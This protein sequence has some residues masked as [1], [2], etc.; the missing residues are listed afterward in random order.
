[1]QWLWIFAFGGLGALARVGLAT[2]LGARAF[3]WSTLAVNLLGCLAIGV[4][5]VLFETL[6]SEAWRPWRVPLIGGFLGGFTTFSAFGLETFTLIGEG[7][8]GAALAYVVASVG[9]GVAGVALGAVLAR[10][11][12]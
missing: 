9:I 7:R 3:P 12:G 2:A 8:T 1:M 10:S 4:G 6:G 5:F 11:L